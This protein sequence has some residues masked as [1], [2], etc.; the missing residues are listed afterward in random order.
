MHIGPEVVN[1]A[2]LRMELALKS[3]PRTVGFA[4]YGIV[5]FK[6]FFL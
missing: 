4:V 2:S 6:G 3:W 1:C 5:Y